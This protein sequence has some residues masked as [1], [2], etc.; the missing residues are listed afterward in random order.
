MKSGGHALK[1]RLFFF[2]KI[3]ARPE[4]FHYF[5]DGPKTSNTVTLGN[6]AAALLRS[7]LHAGL[8]EVHL[9]RQRPHLLIGL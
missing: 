1:N 3:S 6:D 7:L 5:V 2:K 9:H 8:V 4:M